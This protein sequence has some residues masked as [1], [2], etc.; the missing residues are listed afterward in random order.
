MST[1]VPHSNA[2]T[3][4]EAR[5]IGV[6]PQVGLV[7]ALAALVG[8]SC[9]ILPPALAWVGLAGA[10]IANL[11]IFMVYRPYITAFAMIVIC[12]GWAVALRRRVSLRTLVVLGVATIFIA[13]ALLLAHYETDLTR[14]LIAL[15]RKS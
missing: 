14:Y 11:E 10:W 4:R 2:K 3:K 5:M 12:L 13:S 9:C 8:A 15:R 1:V 7:A 6:L